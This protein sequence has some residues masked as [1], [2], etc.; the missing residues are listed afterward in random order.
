MVSCHT[1]EWV[2]PHIW[3]DHATH[4]NGSCHTYKGATPHT[5]WVISRIEMGHGSCQTHQEVAFRIPF[6]HV[7]YTN[8][9]CP[10]YGWGMSHI[11]KSHARANA[12]CPNCGRDMSQYPVSR[13][14]AALTN[15]LCL[16]YGW[17]KPHIWRGHIPY[18]NESFRMRHVP[19][20]KGSYP[21]YGGGMSHI[22]LSHG[23]HM[24]ESC[25]TRE[26]ALSHTYDVIVWHDS[27]ICVTWL[28]HMWYD[29][30]TW[31]SRAHF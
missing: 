11:W 22:W 27:S 23:T 12:S 30:H 3:M 9:S 1:Y 31:P 26:R 5:S 10:T 4:I 14:Y 29:S 28:I 13:R 24:T 19:H 8:E 2:M 17:G 6:S 18:T 7:P 21:V 25:H 15:E 16:K 20:M